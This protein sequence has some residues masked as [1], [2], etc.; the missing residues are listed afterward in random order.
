M[1]KRI[2]TVAWSALLLCAGTAASHAQAQQ[3]YV[4]GYISDFSGPF[5]DTFSP[6]HD[7]FR[8]HI[9]SV[10]AAGGVN[11]R[12][13]KTV[14][15]DDQL[16]A[17]RAASLMRELVT[18]EGVNS[19]WSLEPVEHIARHLR[20]GQTA[21]RAGD[22]VGQ[23][24]QVNAA[25]GRRLRLFHRQRV[26]SRRR[27]VGKARARARADQGQADVR[28]D[29]QCRRLCG[30]WTYHRRGRRVGLHRRFADVPAGQGR[31]RR[32]RAKDR[33]LAAGDRGHPSAGRP[34]ARRAAGGALGRLSRPDAAPQRGVQRSHPGEGD[35]NRRQFREYPCFQ[36]LRAGA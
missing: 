33:K 30:V 13:I 27:G 18:S 7:G 26:R 3:P 22:L 17:T 23:R 35:G 31:V 12:Q 20:S 6:V 8:A 19:I 25:A 32:D 10:N 11:G 28:D 24:H 1:S 29:R 5:V 4:I 16:N 21:Q 15:R 34:R 9:D 36:S 14:V 2:A